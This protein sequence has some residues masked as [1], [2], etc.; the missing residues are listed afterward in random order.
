MYKLLNWYT[1][2]FSFP[3]KGWKY[4][5]PLLHFLN[6]SNKVYRKKI[7]NGLYMRVNARDHIQKNIFW[8]G[9]YEEQVSHVWQNLI[10]DESIVL[11]VG[12]NVGY[13]TLLAAAKARAGNIFSFEP[14]SAFRDLLRQN[15]ALNHFT[16][17]DV[18]TFCVSDKH[19]WAKMYIANEANIGMTALLP[20]ENFSGR[21]ETVETIALDDWT[22]E[23]NLARVD[24]VKIDVEG[25]EKKVLDG[26]KNILQKHQ[27]VLFVEIISA[28]LCKFGSSADEIYSTLFNYNYV[29]YEVTGRRSL[30]RMTICKEGYDILFLPTGYHLPG[31]IKTED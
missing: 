7:F 12:A 24:F 30:K 29:A 27:P 23:K 11:D 17:I 15:I 21:K 13:F 28:Q 9:H 16:N 8:Y 2:R 10:H 5:Q 18:L 20:P 25:A 19:G 4:V 14:I 1:Q 31:T 26:M 3:K 22:K 6:L